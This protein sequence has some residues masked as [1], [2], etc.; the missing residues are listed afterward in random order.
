MG[1][2]IGRHQKHTNTLLCGCGF[3]IFVYNQ[4]EY[5]ILELW[6]YLYFNRKT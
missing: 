2:S 3:C 1:R 5:H 4:G 6:L